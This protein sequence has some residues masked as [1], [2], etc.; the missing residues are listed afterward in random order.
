MAVMAV[1]TVLLATSCI[2]ENDDNEESTLESGLCYI[3]TVKF[4]TMRRK[5]TVKA[6]DGVTDSTYYSTYTTSNRVFSVDHKKLT[7]E[8][9]DSLLY[10]TDLS[11]CVLSLS[12]TGAVAYYR[13]SDA[14]EDDPWVTYNGTDSI[15]LRSPLH[16]RVVATDNTERIYTLTVNVHTVDGELL[17]W[18]AL[19]ADP[20]MSG[21]YP[22][23]AV[24]RNTEM[25]T[26]VND[27]S[28]VLW[29]T[30]VI[31][32]TGE[33][34]KQVT[35]LPE[36]TDVGTLTCH[37]S[38]DRLYVSTADGVLYGSADG[39][40]WSQVCQKE[41]LRFVAVS[42]DKAYALAGG[43]L[44]GA[45]LDDM[46]WAEEMIDEEAALLPNEEVA[47]V[48]YSDKNH[49]TRLILVG[50][51]NVETKDTTAVVWSK[52][53][54]EF[55]DEN[56]EIW[57]HYNRMWDNKRQM[58]ILEHLNL[59]YYDDQLMAIGGKSRDGKV[60]AMDLF[61]V[62][63]D[64]GLTWWNRQDIL[65]P[66]DLAGAQG[67]ITAGVDSDKFLWLMAKGKVYRGRINR[68]GFDRPDIE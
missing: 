61:R 47:S 11:R 32:N 5:L 29:L 45:S 38:T 66:T 8:N 20:L 52:A 31:G 41:G 59:V 40:E 35:N 51:R 50:N 62:S 21:V 42:E 60:E 53:W 39:V 46:V 16:I 43:V 6:S 48:I 3:S 33:W 37:K 68:L 64:N 65:P 13:A 15:D 54:D 55:E 27:G 14:W 24:G 9:R 58:P 49:V 26:M 22:M 4:D 10:N 28:A 7:V 18:N 63:E 57:M 23:K 19:A 44:Y 67:Y 56:A 30:H 1:V 17:Q 34:S 2:S 12:Y 25:G 36:N